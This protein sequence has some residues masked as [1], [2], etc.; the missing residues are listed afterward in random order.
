MSALI[1]SQSSS[2]VERRAHSSVVPGSIPGS[3]SNCIIT[4]AAELQR[5]NV[6]LASAQSRVVQARQALEHA[7]MDAWMAQLNVTLAEANCGRRVCAWC[8][9][10]RDLG[11]CLGIAPG[12]ESHTFCAE[13][14]VRTLGNLTEG[15]A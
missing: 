5:R 3:A 7:E 4:S 14:L 11:P 8:A 1:L 9:P 15:A 2:V 12:A 10:M 6:E 13:C